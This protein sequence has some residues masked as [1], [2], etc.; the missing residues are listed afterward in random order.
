M[1]A[2]LST[3]LTFKW[4]LDSYDLF[5]IAV[6]HPENIGISGKV[7]KYG[8]PFLSLEMGALLANLIVHTSCL[9]YL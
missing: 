5:L 3:V 7:D 1:L 4:L 6:D 8:N 2:I 9:I